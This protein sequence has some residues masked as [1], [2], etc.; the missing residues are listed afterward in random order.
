MI[1]T[2][3]PSALSIV[4]G[5]GRGRRTRA[6]HDPCRRTRSSLLAFVLPVLLVVPV[7]AATGSPALCDLP[8]DSRADGPLPCVVSALRLTDGVGRPSL[9]GRL[10]ETVWSEASR[11]SGFV[12]FAPSPG[13]PASERTEAMVL[14]DDAA[15][16]IGMRMYDTR[17]DSIRAQ[18][19][20]RDD[21]GATSDWAHVFID[22]YLDRRTA[23]HFATTPTG[24]RLDVLH[25]EDT[26][27]DASWNAVWEVATRVEDWGWSAEFRIPL[28][29]LRF[30]GGDGMV[31]G[32]NFMRDIARRSERSYWVEIPPESGR[33]V[34]LFG[35]LDGLQG[36]E[37]PGRL[38]LVPYS[39]AQ[40]RREPVDA[41]DP[42]RD[43]NDLDGSFG[44]D[45]KPARSRS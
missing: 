28:T 45:L 30:G 21:A 2:R 4:I 43:G 9:D 41:G 6:V 42:F 8:S 15:L 19:V 12:Q 23:F 22:S 26:G 32:I 20:R 31:W 1:W 34:S 7:R 35:Q 27:E 44:V 13:S 25:I 38:E 16:W 24:A 10:D 11:A 14:Y 36:L 40:L 3:H 39:L 5:G 33:L 37:P 29:Q 17:P 18:F